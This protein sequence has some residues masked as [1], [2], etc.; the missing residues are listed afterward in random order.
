MTRV[1]ATT[2]S[3]AAK[4]AAPVFLTALLAMVLAGCSTSNQ[5]AQAP[6]EIAPAQTTKKVASVSLAPVAAPGSVSNKMGKMLETA[7]KEKKIPVKGD[8][9]DYTVR[10]YLVASPE[11]EGT[12]VSYI[13]DVTDKSGKR[14]HRFSGEEMVEKRVSGDPWA[15]VDDKAMRKIAATTADR[16]RQWLPKKEVPATQ[17][18]TTGSVN[19]TS[20]T[21]QPNQERSQ[22]ASAQS[23]SSEILVVVPKVTGAPGDGNSA[24]PA[25]MR[26]ELQSR[27]LKLV[28]SKKPNA[29]TV[30]GTVELGEA[31]SGKQPITIRWLVLGPDGKPL[32]NAV[33]QRN[34]IQE[35]SLD[36]SWGRVA[37]IAAGE[38]AKA[39]AKILPDPT[40]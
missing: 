17:V 9:A 34:K 25:A 15:A 27:G 37:D 21:G 1:N 33:V 19:A 2:A 26:R 4:R 40:S 36:G 28:Q 35:G 24:L 14:A 23:P 30:R 3:S 32:K 8:G 22:L 29:Y 18:A 10:G 5:T 20:T 13:W 11:S 7:A 12:K 16:L 39:V 6:A 38:A 31:E